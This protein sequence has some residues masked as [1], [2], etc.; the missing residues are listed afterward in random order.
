MNE[1]NFRY[2]YNGSG[3]GCRFKLERKKLTFRW[4]PYKNTISTPEIVEGRA[5]EREGEILM[6]I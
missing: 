4:N 3:K 6:N 1:K 5:P 2:K